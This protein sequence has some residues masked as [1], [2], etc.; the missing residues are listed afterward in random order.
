KWANCDEMFFMLNIYGPQE[1]EENFLVWNRLLEFI[2]NHEGQFVLF[3]DINE[4]RDESERYDTM[5]SWVEDQIFNSFN[6][7][8]SL[9]DLPLKG[10]SFTWMNKVGTKMSKLDRFHVSNSV[11]DTFPDLKVTALPR[12]YSDH[13][14]LMLHNKKVDYGPL[15]FKFFHSWLHRDGFEECIQAAYAECSLG[16][17]CLTFHEKLKVIKKKFKAWNHMAKNNDF[18]CKQEVMLKLI[19]IE[20]KI[21]NC[22]ASDEEKLQRLNLLKESD[23]LTKL[24]DM[25]M[26]QKAR[27]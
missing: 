15:P 4:V 18:S 23:D 16:D 3:G 5:F 22:S 13:L 9:L 8:E 20:E 27:I 1:K 6:D 19:E 2:R 25:D 12:G 17:T 14:P 7:D 10:R 11:M 21:D 24:D 26:V